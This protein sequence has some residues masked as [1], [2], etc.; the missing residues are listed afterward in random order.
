MIL[1]ELLFHSEFPGVKA[2][3]NCTIQQAGAVLTVDKVINGFNGFERQSITT[4][5]NASAVAAE[6]FQ[7]RFND[8]TTS[9]IPNDITSQIER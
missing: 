5:T 1:Y 3:N 7:L 8:E 9:F 2:L 4:V 6:C